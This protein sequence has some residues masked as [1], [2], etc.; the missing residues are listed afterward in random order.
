MKIVDFL[1]LG[2]LNVLSPK[3]GWRHRKPARSV[4]GQ[5][6]ALRR[7]RRAQGGPGLVLGTDHVWRA[8]EEWL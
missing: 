2:I 6:E 5:R 1:K 7:L 8:R 4:Q 3:R